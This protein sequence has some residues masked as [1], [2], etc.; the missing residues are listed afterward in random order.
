M[1]VTSNTSI[2]DNIALFYMG[3]RIYGLMQRVSVYPL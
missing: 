2:K 3:R 1:K